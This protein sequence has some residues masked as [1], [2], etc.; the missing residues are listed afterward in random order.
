[1]EHNF[2]PGRYA[3]RCVNIDLK[4]E[5]DTTT[6]FQK[7]LAV[8]QWLSILYNVFVVSVTTF[9]VVA[10]VLKNTNYNFLG[11]NPTYEDNLFGSVIKTLRW[12][13]Y[14]P[15]IMSLLSKVGSDKVEL[16][17]T[18]L[19]KLRY[20]DC[21]Q[22]RIKNFLNGFF[23][24]NWICNILL[25]AGDRDLNIQLSDFFH[26]PTPES[27]RAMETP[28]VVVVAVISGYTTVSGHSFYV[29]VLVPAKWKD[30]VKVFFVNLATNWIVL[31][32]YALLNAL[33]LVLVVLFLVGLVLFCVCAPLYC[34][35]K[36]YIKSKQMQIRN[37]AS[38]EEPEEVQ[39][40]RPHVDQSES[41]KLLESDDTHKQTCYANWVLQWTGIGRP[42][43]D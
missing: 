2:R 42:L 39:A 5:D 38:V 27:F 11:L 28:V 34:C 4:K 41:V 18:S 24:L 23:Y 37:D 17:V 6:T 15:V 40:E 43:D 25:L 22:N 16:M 26:N 19:Q 36:H 30:K 8:V 7:L 35:C 1:M 20:K 14:Y 13:N 32:Y 9:L 21:A 12:L 31:L 3:Y 33:F 10:S 29:P